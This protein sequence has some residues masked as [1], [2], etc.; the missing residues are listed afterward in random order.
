MRLL[1]RIPCEDVLNLSLS[2]E[3]E[4]YSLIVVIRNT[5]ADCLVGQHWLWH[6]IAELRS[7]RGERARKRERFSTPIQ[8]GIEPEILPRLMR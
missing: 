6:V 2:M 4:V 3:D 8:S 5:C 1:V 7:C